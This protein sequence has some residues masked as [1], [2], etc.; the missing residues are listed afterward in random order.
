MYIFGYTRKCRAT[1]VESGST[2]VQFS[3]IHQLSS[4]GHNDLLQ[5]VF[6]I[7]TIHIVLGHRI[8]STRPCPSATLLSTYFP[9]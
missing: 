6:V 9:R 7:T 4:E 3:T 1:A 5:V 2:V 8:K